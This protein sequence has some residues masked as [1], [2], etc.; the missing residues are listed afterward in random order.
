[1]MTG[2]KNY[3]LA[4]FVLFCSVITGCINTGKISNVT[5]SCIDTVF[6]E[7]DTLFQYEMRNS[8]GMVIRIT[9]YAAALTD[10][11]VPDRNGHIESVVLG[12]DSVS[13][14]TKPNP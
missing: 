13:E 5:V 3:I 8:S 6:I 11:S 12:F 10:V 7:N 1:M 9:N 14:Y 4:L 2:I